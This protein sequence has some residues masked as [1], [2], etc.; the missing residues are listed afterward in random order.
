MTRGQKRS[1]ERE[2]ISKMPKGYVFYTDKPDRTIT[3]LSAIEGRKV[4]TERGC[5]LSGPITE[6]KT[7]Y[8]LKVTILE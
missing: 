7:N 4:R 8:L 5:F 3:S 1:I 6:P 2:L